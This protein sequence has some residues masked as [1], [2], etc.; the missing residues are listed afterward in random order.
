MNKLVLATAVAL[1]L[2]LSNVYAEGISDDK[3]K[4]GVLADMGG[5]YA[6]VCGKGCVAAVEMAVADFGGKVLDKPIEVVSADDQNKPDI[7]SA[8]VREW[9]DKDKV[10]AVGGIVASSVGLAAAKVTNEAKKPLLISTAGSTAFT[11]KQCSP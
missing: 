11:T 3:V 8:V 7:G 10:D 6:D 4:I 1:G 5:T 9:L 2:A